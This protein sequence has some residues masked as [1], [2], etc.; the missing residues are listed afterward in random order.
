MTPRQQRQSYQDAAQR[1]NRQNWEL[2][3]K[4]P[5]TYPMGCAWLA[6]AVFIVLVI[7]GCAVI[8]LMG[9]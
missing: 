5:S 3:N 4:S 9:G 2:Y 7:G 1:T 6:L 8:T